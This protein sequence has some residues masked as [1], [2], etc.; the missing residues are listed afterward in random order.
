MRKRQ[1]DRFERAGDEFHAR[2]V[3]GF[4]TMAADDPEH[5]ITIDA[6]GPLDLVSHQIR[7]SVRDRLGV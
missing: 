6:S 3:D 2:V 4:A 1:L 5:W 7:R